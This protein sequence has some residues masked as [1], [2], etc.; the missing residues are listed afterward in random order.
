M[1]ELYA[2]KV[3]LRQFGKVAAEA[4]TGHIVP[5]LKVATAHHSEQAEAD[6]Q[7]EGVSESAFSGA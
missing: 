6:T 5:E 3:P 2:L 7:P 4:G 1:D